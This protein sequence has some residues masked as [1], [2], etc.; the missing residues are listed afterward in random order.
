MCGFC[1]RCHQSWSRQL[2]AASHPV[3]QNLKAAQAD[4]QHAMADLKQQHAPSM[5]HFTGVSS[6][7]RNVAEVCPGI[8]L[9]PGVLILV[10]GLV[11][12]DSSE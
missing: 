8:A 3:W 5:S 1:C 2:Q 6:L 7:L 11:D 12:E 10:S 9:M 4:Y